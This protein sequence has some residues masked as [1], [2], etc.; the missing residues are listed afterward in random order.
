MNNGANRIQLETGNLEALGRYLDLVL[1]ARSFV[2][3]EEPV[4]GAQLDLTLFRQ[5]ARCGVSRRAGLYW[6][7]YMPAIV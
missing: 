1:Q 7:S 6:H 5:A 3:P 4:A 2:V